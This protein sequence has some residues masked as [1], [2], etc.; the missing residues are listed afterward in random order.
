MK[1]LRGIIVLIVLLL[2]TVCAGALYADSEMHWS[3]S[4][5]YGPQN[6]H[7]LPGSQANGKKQSPIN[8]PSDAPIN[9]N[10]IKFFYMDSLL[11]IENNGHTIKVSYERGSYILV[12]GKK[13]NLLQFHFHAPSEHTFS[14]EHFPM[15]THFVHQSDDGEYAVIGL[16]LKKGEYNSAYASIWEHFPEEGEKKETDTVINAKTL[17]P[18]RKS[19]YRYD[20][21]FTTPPCTEGVKWFVLK[22]SVELSDDQ[23]SQFE[24]FYK[25]NNRPIQP[26]NRRGFYLGGEEQKKDSFL[27]VF[28]IIGIVIIAI[29]IMFF[30]MQGKK[31]EKR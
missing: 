23:I 10:G 22:D 14:G 17:L 5:E 12:E 9:E 24:K 28:V 16:F 21:S 18:E 7:K 25:S 11:N 8:I 30:F 6:W 29:G 1:N 2:F 20:G 15:E 27:P 31:S 19:Y 3:Y 13:Y 26:F 4:G